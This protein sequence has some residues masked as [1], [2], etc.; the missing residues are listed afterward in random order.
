MS[1]RIEDLL[2]PSSLPDPTTD[3]RL[4]QTHISM[5]LV[6]DDFVY[7]IKKPVDFGFLNFSTLELR[8][9]YCREEVR[10]NQRLSEDIYLGVIPVTRDK[11]RD[12]LGGSGETVDY[13]VRMRRIPEQR[14]MRYL[15]ERGE[16]KE[17]HL[18][19][20]ARVLAD[21]HLK[22][23]RSPTID[24][25]GHWENFKVNTDENFEQTAPYIGRTIDSQ[26][27]AEIKR[28]TEDFFKG[29]S[30]LFEERVSSG[31]IRD[32][33]GDLHMEHICLLDEERVAVID[34]IEFNDR[35]RYTDTLADIAFL[36]MDLEFRGGYEAA[37]CLWKAYA[38]PACESG[39]ERLLTFYKV[40]RAYVR[41]KVMGFQLDDQGVSPTAREEAAVVAGK[42]FA[43]ARSYIEE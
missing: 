10:L 4:I 11:G 32:C 7:K 36:L 20:V 27:Y 16:L 30:E 29:Y 2:D 28:W 39:M 21:F 42:Y 40:Y 19:R 6:G 5:V 38:E 41:G 14:L 15:Y 43:L 34:C 17:H 35:F 8:G 37:E 31:R 24:N 18:K 23:A 22:A 3:V 25:F 33:H 13:A 26:D 9:H 12:R 1:A